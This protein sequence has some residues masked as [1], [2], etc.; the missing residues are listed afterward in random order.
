MVI[1][2]SP[3][4]VFAL[5]VF[6]IHNKSLCQLYFPLHINLVGDL[7]MLPRVLHVNRINKLTWLLNW[8]IMLGSKDFGFYVFRTL[9]CIVCKP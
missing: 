5:E 2:K 7:F 3:G 1:L 6:P 4:G 9:F 8:L